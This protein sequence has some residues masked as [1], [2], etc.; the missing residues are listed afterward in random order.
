M[1]GRAK[2][3]DSHTLSSEPSICDNTPSIQAFDF[4]RT[5]NFGLDQPYRLQG[6]EER[7]STADNLAKRRALRHEPSVLRQLH[8][9]WA[10]MP[11]QPAP[12]SEGASE[13][14]DEAG[15]GDG[16][17]ED[18]VGR[19][20]F[21]ELLVRLIRAL[22]DR[23]E[24]EEEVGAFFPDTGSHPKR[25]AALHSQ[26]HKLSFAHVMRPSPLP[27]IANDGRQTRRRPQ[28]TFNGA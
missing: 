26:H 14:E 24:K 4:E 5:A 10:L 13:G 7:W 17:E 11:K 20:D 8:R 22:G 21:V 18:V 23:E 16:G 6:D 9:F 1:S 12:Q 3:R 2:T 27:A 15:D 25:S 28:L 19:A